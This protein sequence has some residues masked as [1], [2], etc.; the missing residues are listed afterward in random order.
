MPRESLRTYT[1]LPLVLAAG[2]APALADVTPSDPPLEF[3]SFTPVPV[4]PSVI[5]DAGD[6]GVERSTEP[7][8][9]PDSFGSL[10][11]AMFADR[12]TSAFINTGGDVSVH[13]GPGSTDLGANVNGSGNVLGSWDEYLATDY[14]FIQVVW[15]TENGED[16][17][18]LGAEIGGEPALFLGWRFGGGEAVR[19]LNW[20]QSVDLIRATVGLSDDGGTTVSAFDITGAFTNPWDATDVGLSLA[21]AGLGINYIIT[22]YEYNAI[23]APSA[24]GVLTLAGLLAA[25]RR[26]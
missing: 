4:D 16:F 3:R 25:R 13:R 10:G 5:R 11:V 8:V 15:W 19:F 1:L 26:R 23:P 7:A 21:A 18:P 17:L 2:A 9:H 20:V 12:D 24:A 14:N 6:P 22:Q